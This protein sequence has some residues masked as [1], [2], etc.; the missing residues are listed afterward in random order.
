[1]IKPN[2]NELDLCIDHQHKISK[3]HGPATA[4]YD[5]VMYLYY[6]LKVVCE[7]LVKGVE[8]CASETVPDG[9]DK[10]LKDKKCIGS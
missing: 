7:P 9:C 8:L 2:V 5:A 10:F 3:D 1:M 4:K 6:L